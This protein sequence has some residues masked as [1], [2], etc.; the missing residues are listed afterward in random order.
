MSP[1]FRHLLV[2]F[3][4]VALFSG[5]VFSCRKA[6]APTGQPPPEVWVTPVVRKD[7]PIYQEW[8]GTLN[9][10]VNSQVR[11]RVTG[12][13][14]SQHYKEGDFV[15]EGDLLFTIDPRPLQAALEQAQGELARAQANEKLAS[16]NFK[17]A[18]ELY[19][20][21]VISAQER[22]TMV[23]NYGTSSADVQAQTAAVET[24]RLNLEFSR[25]TAPVAGIAG[26]A[27]AHVG[28]LVGPN[29]AQAGPLT[30]VSRVDP[31]KAEF[32]LTEQDYLALI[33]RESAPTAGK[34]VD[35]DWEI[36]LADGWVYPKKGRF[37]FTDRQVDPTTGAI[38]ATLL[39]PNPGNR[40]RPGLFCRVR[41][42]TGVAKGA[43][44]VPQ[45]A[46]LEVQGTSM[47]VVINGEQKASF[48]PVELGERQDQWR[49]VRKGVQP[50]ERVIVEG[51][52]KARD[53][54]P[55]QPREWREP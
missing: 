29:S 38:R 40:L 55:V 4:W 53:G 17:R 44:L 36:V 14:V 8:V 47:V 10:F 35:G 31:I 23:A 16:A 21:Q 26:T 51:L 30:T 43:L 33:R 46:I 32:N 11:A 34:G 1:V 3:C 49:I 6:G 42:R 15:N 41:A 20:R 52:Q 48:R 45:R 12:Y 25:I 28:D 54:Q 50:G 18:Q 27:T 13:L 19:K 5:G 2:W 39:F 9:G 24:A 22:D 37:D 7:V